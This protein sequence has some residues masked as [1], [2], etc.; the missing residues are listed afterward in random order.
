MDGRKPYRFAVTIRVIVA[1]MFVINKAAVDHGFNGFSATDKQGNSSRK[2][3]MGAAWIKGTFVAVLAVLALRMKTMLVTVTQCLFSTVQSF[4]VAV[5]AERDFSMWKVWLDISLLTVVYSCM[6]MKGPVF[7]TAW[8]P[9][10]FILTIFCSSFLGEMVHVGSVLVL[11]GKSRETKTGQCNTETTTVDGAQG[12][13]HRELEGQKENNG[14]EA[15]Q[16]KAEFGTCI[17]QV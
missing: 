4:F 14:R 12:E 5:V 17:Q 2:T 6:E 9:L 10:T 13:V 15:E 11:W 8:T 1:G 16:E 3:L 7:L